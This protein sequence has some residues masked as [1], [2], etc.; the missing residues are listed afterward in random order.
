MYLLAEL[1]AAI[2]EW[3]RGRIYAGVQRRRVE[4]TDSGATND[5][6]E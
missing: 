6:D 2:G 5:D 1:L 4:E 3:I